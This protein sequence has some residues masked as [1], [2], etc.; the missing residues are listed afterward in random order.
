MTLGMTLGV[1]D[2]STEKTKCL[3]WND[4]RNDKY[5]CQNIVFKQEKGTI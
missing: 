2:T 3:V 4:I 1:T 5:Q